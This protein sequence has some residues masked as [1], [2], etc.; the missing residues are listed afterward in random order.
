MESNLFYNMEL[1][2]INHVGNIEIYKKI[3]VKSDK[4]EL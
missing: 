4:V 3:V 1:L 2:C